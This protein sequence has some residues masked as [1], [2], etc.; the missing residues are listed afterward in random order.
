LWILLHV[1][2]LP[3]LLLAACT[4]LVAPG[5]SSA[6]IADKAESSIDVRLEGPAAEAHSVNRDFLFD[7]RWIE[8]GAGPIRLVLRVDTDIVKR[9]DTEGIVAGHIGVTAWRIEGADKRRLLWSASEL[10]DRGEISRR[11]PVFVVRQSGCCGGR[12]SF[13]V[14]SLYGGRRLFSATG[15]DAATCWAQMDVPNSGGLVRLVALHAAYSIVDDA[16]FG[17]RKETVGLLTYAAPDRPLA[18]YR[19][20]ARSAEAIEEFMGDA[21]VGLA[22]GGNAEETDSLTLWPANGKR[23]PEAIGGFAILLHLTP[24]KLVRIPVRGDKLDLAGASLPAGLKIEAAPL[25]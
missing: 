2:P 18:R 11:Q 4:A 12:D 23:D 22:G 16:A 17:G 10:G 6:Q 1:K 19:L 21:T 20:V 7:S 25:P 13:S 24:D 14:F 15:A 3:S 9:D 5:A 8:G